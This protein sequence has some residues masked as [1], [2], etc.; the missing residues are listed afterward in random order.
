VD[1]ASA[2]GL[3]HVA[4]AYL[5]S[6]QKHSLSGNTALLIG[7]NNDER[8]SLRLLASLQD[9]E[10]I[11]KTTATPRASAYSAIHRLA[12]KPN[13]LLPRLSDNSEPVL[14]ALIDSGI[15]LDAHPKLASQLWLNHAEQPDGLDNDNSG[16]IDDLTGWDF[17]GRD[18]LGNDEDGHGT[19]MASLITKR[20]PW[21]KLMNL[22]VL[23]ENGEGYL[24]DISRA[25]DYAVEQQADV[26]NL[27][28]GSK[29]WD[30]ELYQSIQRALDAGAAVV[31]ATGNEGRNTPNFPASVKG[32]WAAGSINKQGEVP[33]WSN[34]AGSKGRQFVQVVSQHIKTAS[35]AGGQ[36]FVS[37]TSAACARLSRLLAGIISFQRSAT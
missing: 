14:V 36:R 25:V 19:M 1:S 16:Y 26:I 23:D 18:P 30:P 37:G 10:I 21:I 11:K 20:A 29:D 6:D 31:A 34:D 5:Q 4:S 27:S 17:V 33:N 8:S 24:S 13:L 9:N 12:R 35:L 28:L 7:D 15:H 2:Y 32:V 3:Q 22:R